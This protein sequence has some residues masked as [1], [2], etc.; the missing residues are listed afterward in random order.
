[1]HTRMRTNIDPPNAPNAPH[2]IVCGPGNGVHL[3]TVCSQE[4]TSFEGGRGQAIR[5]RAQS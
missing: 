3:V 5:I 1:M 4:Q 2:V